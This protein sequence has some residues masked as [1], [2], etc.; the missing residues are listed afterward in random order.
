MQANKTTEKHLATV[1]YCENI[2]TG[3]ILA[4]IDYTKVRL[5]NGVMAL[6]PNRQHSSAVYARQTQATRCNKLAS[7]Q[8]YIALSSHLF[9]YAG[10]AAYFYLQQ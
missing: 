2:T 10:V 1:F 5:Q 4:N 9:A 7:R 8:S 6:T 3:Y